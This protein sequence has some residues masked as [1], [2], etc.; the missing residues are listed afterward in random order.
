MSIFRIIVLTLLIL[1]PVAA[2]D[3]PPQQGGNP[4]AGEVDQ[5][6]PKSTM[7]MSNK[8]I[9]ITQFSHLVPHIMWQ[10]EISPDPDVNRLFAF[11]D[12]NLFQIISIGLVFIV[13]TLVLGSFGPGGT[14]W[15]IR[16]FRGWCLWL[17]DEVV[18]GVM[19]KEEGRAFAPYF[20]F[21]FFFLIFGNLISIIPG[22]V[23]MAATVFVTGALSLITFVM[24]VVGGM[25]RQGVVKYWVSL[26]PPN[27][28][29]AMIP[30]M[31][32]I[33]IIALFVRPFA[34][35]IRLFANML[36]GH[37]IIYSFI[38]MI[39]LFAKMMEMG[40]IAW[41]TT[42]PAIGLTVFI[43]IIESFVA[44]L[45]A[46]IFTYLSVIFVQQSLHPAH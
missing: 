5:S 2:Q 43:L 23:T 29:I 8:E 20:I 24:M 44:I 7:E 6:A 18:Y 3:V 45:Q 26:L 4:A 12:V 31:V 14:P 15:I 32:V 9:F 25:L 35:T 34:L 46:Y 39:F 21:L 42:I 16:I 33:E 10:P 11:Y 28:P 1:S 19:G 38:G 36:A 40:W 22:S 30:L 27:L 13:F 41:A 17:R 37:L